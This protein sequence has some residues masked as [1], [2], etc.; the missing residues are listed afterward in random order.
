MVKK[1]II[2]LA[3][4]LGKRMQTDIPKVLNKI[5]NIPMLVILLREICKDLDNIDKILI[6][7]GKYRSQIESTLLEY[8]ALYK[9]I[10][11]IY[12]ENTLGT[13]HAV[14]C[15]RDYLLTIANNSKI[16]IL[17]GDTPLISLKTMSNMFLVNN[18]KIL[19]TFVDDATGV[20]R[21]VE[22][23]EKLEQ[24]VEHKDC[25]ESQLKIKKVN[26]G[27]YSVKNSLLIKYI[28]QIDNKNKQN[29]YYLT[30]IIGLIRKGEN[31]DVEELSVLKAD[32]FQVLGVNTKYQLE[33]LEKLYSQSHMV[34]LI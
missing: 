31:V 12:Q 19:T 3:G 34:S 29:E 24:I 10:Q 25:T 4:G 26:C 17:Y 16:L 27:I 22:A 28:D 1:I 13:G 30:D 2:I 21:I 32:N 18:I 5:N 8:N 33:E 6:V 15:C 11:F 9:H 7:V 14:L 23:D 20:G